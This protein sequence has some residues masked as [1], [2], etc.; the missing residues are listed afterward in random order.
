MLPTMLAPTALA[1]AGLLIAGC[2]FSAPS[3]R[4]T[5]GLY[6]DLQRLVS[7]T[8]ATGWEIDRVE[9]EDLLSDALM[10]VCRATPDRRDELVDWLDVEIARRGGSAELAWRRAGKDLDDVDALLELTRIRLV[11]ARALQAADEDCPFWVEPQEPFRPRQISDGRWQLSLGGGGKGILVDTG[12]RTDIDFG[13][14]GRLM[15]GYNFDRHALFLGT[16]LGA[17]ASFPKDASGARSSVRLAFDAVVPVVYRYTL[18]NTYLEAELGYLGR[19]LE[20][21]LS[22]VAHGVH[23]GIALGARATRQRLLFPGAAFGI[24]YERTV[25][26]DPEG[27]TQLLKVGFRVAFDFD[28]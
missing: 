20:D 24:S 17:A 1:V 6:R 19:A 2:S 10:S 18:V 11:L 9:A 7:V 27:T 16:E 23:V 26:G 25:A 4:S 21:E 15:V 28:W 12:D 22:D 14:A 13:G 8:A 3:T 5:A